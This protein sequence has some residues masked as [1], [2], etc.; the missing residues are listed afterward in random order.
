MLT[1]KYSHEQYQN[2]VH[3]LLTKFYIDSNQQITLFT[4]FPYLSKLWNADL[5]SIVSLIRDSYSSSTQGAP[6]KDSVAMLRS[7]ILMS[8]KSE[9]SIPAWVDTL[10]SDPFFAILSGFIPACLGSSRIEGVNADPIPGVGTFY[11]FMDRLIRKDRIL[12]KSSLRRSRRKPKSKQKKN[13]KMDSPSTTLSERLVNRII[14]YSHSK[15]P[16][17]I[18]SSLN[19]ILKEL[20]VLPSINMKLLG[21]PE[22]FNIAGDGTCMPTHAS[23]YGKKICDCVL[24][25]WEHCKCD[26][27]L[28][29]PSAT[30]GWDSYNERYFYGHT[31]HVFTASD[32]FYSLPI[33][34]KCVT[35]ERHDSIT[36]IYALKELVDL[37][38]ALKFQFAAFDS[39]YDSTHFYRLNHFYK[40]TPIIALNSRTLKPESSEESIVFDDN[41]IPQVK[42][43]GHKLRNW[44]L[45]KKSFR[46]KWLF[47]VQCDNCNK[48]D[49]CSKKTFYTP[50]QDNPRFFGSILRGTK[51]WAKLYKRR[52]TTER[53]NDR[54]KYDFGAK[55]AIIN[56]RERRIVKSFIAA[57]CCYIDAWNS[58]KPLRINDIFPALNLIA[59]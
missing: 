9:L 16:D 18:E 31:L 24:K 51:K 33:H 11:D 21:N 17:S 23:H 1:V 46:R 40:I 13:Q 22:K 27:K 2:F 42:K 7:L 55:S 4:N 14:K 3:D 10:R 25:P 28:S 8:F 35:G 26:R 34:I 54:L 41:G 32:S 20:F 50:T 12:H 47:P 6:P 53:F 15:L 56:S 36:G 43:C 48:C 19:Q 44:G 49:V 29:D 30:W 37:Y 59:A 39:G 38:P 52:T 58:E 45:M 57:F 5:T